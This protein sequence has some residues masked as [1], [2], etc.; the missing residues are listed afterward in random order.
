MKHNNINI[1]GISEGEE[2]EQDIENLFEIIM[3]KN[4]L[5]WRGKWSHKIRK[6]RGSQ[7]R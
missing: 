6:H 2:K 5:T 3:M 4:S 1:I 7:S